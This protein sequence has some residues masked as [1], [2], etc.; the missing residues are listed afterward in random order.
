MS[1]LG[2]GGGGGGGGIWW[3]AFQVL[4]NTSVDTSKVDTVVAKYSKCL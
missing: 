3:Q 2:G 4:N 1:N